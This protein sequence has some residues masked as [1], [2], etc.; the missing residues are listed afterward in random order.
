MVK[1]I[2]MGKVQGVDGVGIESFL[3]I[4]GD[5]SPG[6]TD[7]YRLTMTD[8]TTV[9]VSVYNGAD[10]ADGAGIGDMLKS[11]YD[12]TN[13]G[14][15]DDADKVNGLTVETAVPAGAL[16]SD[17]VYSHPAT[18]A[19]S[20]ILQDIDNRFVTDA[21]IA[22][23]NSK[24]DGTHTH[25]GVYEPAN[26]NIQSHIS[27]SANPHSVTAAQVS[28]I[29]T[30]QKGA[31]SGIA[32]LDSDSKLDAEQVAIKDVSVSASTTLAIAHNNRRL[33]CEAAAA[34]NL[35][36][37]PSA[38]TSYVVGHETL[39]KSDKDGGQVSLVKGAGVILN[40]IDDSLLN[41]TLG[42]S[43]ILKYEGSDVWAVDGALE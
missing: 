7:V 38:T 10:G 34:M 42:G 35:T 1:T 12:T 18:H 13:N 29:A 27:N 8:A 20:V 23:W 15:V 33:F 40:A 14:K 39:V 19:P 21:Q 5:G 22:S 9:D 25:T 17:T 41:I 28:A 2:N 37:N 24:A 36:I 31:A 11:E 26:A 3:L 6:T 16:F 30:S 32:E 4:S 43:V